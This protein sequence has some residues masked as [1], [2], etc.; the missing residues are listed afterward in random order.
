MRSKPFIRSR[1][2]VARIVRDNYGPSW[3]DM[4]KAVERRDGPNCS[5][6]N[7]TPAQVKARGGRFETHHLTPLSKGGLTA[8]HNLCR[9]CDVCHQRKHPHHVIQKRPAAKKKT[10]LW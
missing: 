3:F 6:C 1:G 4:I 9:L 10:G 7:A 5:A 8:M 2:G